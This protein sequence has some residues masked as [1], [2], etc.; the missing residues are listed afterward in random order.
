MDNL[1]PV[2]FLV[3]FV[4]VQVWVMPKFGDGSGCCANGDPRPGGCKPQPHDKQ[5]GGSCPR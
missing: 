1:L 5:A 2:L 4:L 3:A